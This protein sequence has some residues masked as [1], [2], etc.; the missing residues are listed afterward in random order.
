MGANGFQ[1]A[2]GFG[3]IFQKAIASAAQHRP[4]QTDRFFHLPRAKANAIFFVP[5]AE[6]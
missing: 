6:N 2:N 4:R 3:M 1:F 5:D